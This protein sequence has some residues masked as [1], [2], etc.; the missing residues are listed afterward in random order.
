MEESRIEHQ[1]QK[2]LIIDSN[3][4]RSLLSESILIQHLQSALLNRRIHAPQRQNISINSDDSN[5]N[6]GQN[7]N[8]PP[9]GT[10]LV[11]PAWSQSPETPYIG[12]KIVT[13][14]PH[15]NTHKGIPSLNATYMLSGSYT[16]RPLA[17]I[18]GTEITHWRTSCIS[19]LAASYL[20]RQDA[21]VLAMVGAGQLAPYLIMAHLSVRPSLKKIIVWNRTPSKAQALVENLRGRLG[22]DVGIECGINLDDIVRVAD[23]ISCATSSEVP[24]VHGGF[25]KPGTHLDLVGSFCPS[26]KECDDEAVAKGRIFVDCEVALKEAG[27]LVGAFER[28]IIKPQDVV[29]TLAQLGRGEMGG[30]TGL[31]EITLFKS[32]GSAAVDLVT[33][34]LVYEKHVSIVG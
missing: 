29:G 18:D 28:G 25:L 32:V 24:L 33:A 7:S 19:A 9:P 6:I 11:M 3:Q 8:T 20:A 5:N 30:R 26:M 2:I 1:Q 13:A 22:H 15:N 10:L 4:V 17:F 21:H 12:V 27:E 34:Q 16:G 31:Q 23:V 14:F